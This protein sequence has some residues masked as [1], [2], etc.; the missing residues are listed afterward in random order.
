[1]TLGEYL[2]RRRGDSRSQE[3]M[4]RSLGVS[5]TTYVQWESGTRAPTSPNFVALL[6][7]LRVPAEER[8]TVLVLHAEAVAEA[9]RLSATKK[10]VRAARDDDAKLAV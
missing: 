10:A 4:A 5:R 1:M 8:A 7:A 2:K 6:D 9:A 3:E